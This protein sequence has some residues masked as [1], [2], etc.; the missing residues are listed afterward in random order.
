MIVQLSDAAERDLIDGIAF[1]DDGDRRAG[2]YF[3]TSMQADLR[4]L[5]YL[6]GVHAKRHGY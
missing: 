4:S 6:G 3:L 5:E 2:D 1:Y